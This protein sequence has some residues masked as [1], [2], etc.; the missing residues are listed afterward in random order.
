APDGAARTRTRCLPLYGADL[1]RQGHRQDRVG[2]PRAPGRPRR[3]PSARGARARPRGVRVPV[4][5]APD[6]H[7]AAAAARPGEAGQRPL[8][9]VV[10]TVRFPSAAE[11]G[12]A[13]V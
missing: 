6:T 9:V 8:D 1:S 12:R 10:V 3:V 13:H 11:T 4:T 7:V 5:A 2:E